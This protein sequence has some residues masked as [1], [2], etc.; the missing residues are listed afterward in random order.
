[1]AVDDFRDIEIEH[2]EVFDQFFRQDPPET[3]ELSFTNLFIWRHRNH[4][5]WLEREGCLMVVLRPAGHPAFGLPPVGPGNK[6]AAL[7]FLFEVLGRL[8]PNARVCRV[9]EAFVNAHVDHGRY[10][11]ILDRDNSDYVYLT[12]D[13][14]GLSGR[15]YHRKKNHLNRFVKTYAYEY[16]QMDIELVECFLDMQEKWCEIRECVN[17]PELLAEDYAVYEALTY[18]EALD[19]QGAAIEIDSRIEAF[20]LGEIL[21]PK[22]AVIHI[23]KANPDISGLYVA[24]NQLFCRNAW[25]EFEYI[26]REQDLGIA[27]LRTAKESYFPHHMVKKY[28]VI[29]KKT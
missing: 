6:G 3:S 24:M 1:M 26:N 22:T 7:D 4:P 17:N 27:G 18:F 15:K 8:S 2:K 5:L 13:L 21:N 23:E 20:S 19:Y 10:E 14:I 12:K 28:T 9:G 16:R 29:P 11:T 25:S